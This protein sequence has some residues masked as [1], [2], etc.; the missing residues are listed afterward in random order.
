MHEISP[1]VLIITP[2]SQ[3]QRG[4]TLTTRRICAGLTRNGISA[5]LFSL[6]SGNYRVH[7]EQVLATERFNIIHVFNGTYL[8]Q[9]LSSHPQLCH[10]PLIVTLTGT[11]IN[12]DLDDNPSAL[13]PVFTAASRI[14]V[15]HQDFKNKLLAMHQEQDKIAVIPQG[16]FLPPAA[17]RSRSAYH[18][19]A[20]SL[21]FLLPT[22]LRPVKNV[23]LALDSLELLARQDAHLHLLIIG[24]VIDEAYGNEIFKRIKTLP[25][26]IYLGEIPHAEISGVYRLGDAVIN[27]SYAEGQPQAVLEA[28]SLGIPAILSDVPGNR[29]IIEHGREGF[30]VSDQ[31]DFFQAART[32]LQEP[33]RRRQMGQAA[34]ELV[35]TRF[36]A[37]QEIARHIDL[38]K[39][40]LKEPQCR[41]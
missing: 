29:G 17:A 6:E 18:I 33:A 23:A 9:L 1:K 15:F 12:Q 27:C 36:D 31:A 38:Y 24:P 4:N 22:G 16:V 14:I 32:L 7:L 13:K 19:P 25:W 35:Q 41:I 40:V 28:M 5:E 34:A 11:D 10:Y 3:S 8:A 2:F 26:A 21:V 39:K 37:S 20:D 30:Y